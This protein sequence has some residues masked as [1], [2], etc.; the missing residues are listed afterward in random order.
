MDF[1]D[2]YKILGVEPD[3]D[4]KAIKTAYRRLARKYHPDVSED[5]DAEAKF[6]DIAEAY[7]ALKDPEKRA[8]YD[9]LRKYGQHGQRFEPPPDWQ[10]SFQ[11]DDDFSDF[12]ESI[13][14][15]R[16]PRAGRQ[17]YTQR[18]TH[19]NLRGQDIETELP[20]FLEETLADER[21]TI[22]YHLPHYDKEG[23]RLADIKKTLNV[24]IPKGVSEGE[25]IR[26]KGQGGPGIGTGASGDLYLHI[27]LVPHPL[28]DVEGHNLTITVPIS[29]WEAVL[30]TKVE[31][32]TLS[33]SIN[34]TLPPNSQTGKRLRIKGKGLPSKTGSGDLYAVVK[35]VIPERSDEETKKIWESLSKKIKFNP[36]SEWSKT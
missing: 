34:L 20:I 28:F 17:Q 9:E 21:K 19:F 24:K 16:G 33:G 8:E 18:E 3:A 23:R 36:R 13:F 29:P 12:F 14:G 11:H 10:S 26:L 32:P 22:S 1:K 4:L 6:K 5:K 35:I 27:R 30:G 7:A 31:V 15:S 25:R 2:Y